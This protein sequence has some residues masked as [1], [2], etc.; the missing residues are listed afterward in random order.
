M[1][2]GG[3]IMKAAPMAIHN[4][5]KIIKKWAG[6]NPASQFCMVMRHAPVRVLSSTQIV[7]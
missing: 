4:S 6:V 3:R 2:F 1:F 7:S 5:A